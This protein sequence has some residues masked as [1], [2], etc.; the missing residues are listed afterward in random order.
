MKKKDIFYTI[1]ILIFS[2]ICGILS[3]D[4]FIGTVILACGLLNSY[5]ASNGK[6][7]NYLFGAIYALF[8][9]YVSF[10]NGLYGLA[11]LSVL[12]YFPSQ[13][14]G[15]LSWKKYMNDDEVNVRGFTLKLSILIVLICIAGSFGFGYLLSLIPSQNLAFLDSSSNIINLCAV[16]LMNLRYKEAWMIWLFNNTIDLAIWIINAVKGTPNSIMMLLVSIGFLLINFY[17]L[18]K[19]I[20]SEKK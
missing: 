15:Y 8:V 5:Y 13:I 12:V 3:K 14:Q 4:Y 17:G 1:I 16:V 11:V 19:W 18:Y 10:I 7:I 9:A 6:I 2:I 20:K